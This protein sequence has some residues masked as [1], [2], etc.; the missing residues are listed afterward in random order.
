MSRL[1]TAF[2]F[3]SIT[4]ILTYKYHQ[5]GIVYNKKEDENDLFQEVSGCRPRQS[6]GL[7]STQLAP[8]KIHG[9]GR[10]VYPVFRE[11]RE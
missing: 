10:T 7:I 1:T 5:D 3:P 4:H 8:Q 9:L 2:R 6:A 11:I